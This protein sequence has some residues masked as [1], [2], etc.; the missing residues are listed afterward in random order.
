MRGL[1][2]ALT[3]I[4]SVVFLSAGAT[5]TRPR[6]AGIHCVLVCRCRCLSVFVGGCGV[7]RLGV[8]CCRRR[9]R[10]LCFVSPC[11]DILV[12]S[13]WLCWACRKT[14]QKNNWF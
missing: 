2:F 5:S 4:V 3:R 12:L 10:V 14:K 9:G 6:F 8:G 11:I 13:A 7:V 1:P